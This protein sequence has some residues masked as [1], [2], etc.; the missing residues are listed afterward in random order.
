MLSHLAECIQVLT[1]L[2]SCKPV[3]SPR[4]LRFVFVA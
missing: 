1:H 4:V 3:H 2:Q